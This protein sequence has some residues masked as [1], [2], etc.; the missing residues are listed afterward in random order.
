MNLLQKGNEVLSLNLAAQFRVQSSIRQLTAG[1][2]ML[3][4]ILAVV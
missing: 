2:W 4:R 1:K 3:L